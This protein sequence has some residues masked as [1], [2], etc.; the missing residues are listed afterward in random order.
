M[1]TLASWHVVYMDWL[2]SLNQNQQTVII[3][4]NVSII[5]A[6][7]T[8]AFLSYKLGK[9]LLYKIA[10][11]L[12]EKHENKIIQSLHHNKLFSYLSYYFPLLII[13]YNLGIIIARHAKN[14]VFLEKIYGILAVILFVLILNSI[15]NSVIEL[16]QYKKENR[17]KPIKGLVQFLQI[18]IYFFSAVVCVSILLSSSPMKLI[19][20]LGAA[21]AVLMLIF[22]DSI[23]GLVGGVQLSLNKT[24]EIGDWVSLPKYEA[25]GEVI[26]ITLTSLRIRNWDNS[27]STVPSYNLIVSDSI[28]NWKGMKKAGARRISRFINID[29]SSVCFCTPEMIDSFMKIEGV[30]EAL[31]RVTKMEEGFV[32]GKDFSQKENGLTNLG[33]FRAYIYSYLEKKNEIRKD[34]DLMVRQKQPVLNGLPFEIY[35]FA[36]TTVTKEYETIQADIF[37]HVLAVLPYFGLRIYQTQISL[38]EG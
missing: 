19:A 33:V 5:L 4:Y 23:S 15:L 20:G 30:K 29:M 27:I 28:K 37:D 10:K 36:N 21:S 11:R 24:V 38:N 3:I 13:R 6:T 1:I 9:W 35:C 31:N 7:I 14:Y 2:E 17:S 16:N 18:I 25:D 12:G 22:K 26:D 34:M 8:L 32:I